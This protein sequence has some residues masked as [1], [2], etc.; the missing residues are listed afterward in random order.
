MSS[1][2]G[3]ELDRYVELR[4][5]L[6][7][8]DERHRLYALEYAEQLSMGE[9]APSAAGLDRAI[10]REVRRRIWEEWLTRIRAMPGSR[11]SS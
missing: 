7:G 6:A 11:W 4:Q 8:L 10:V 5:Y 2:F 3:N 1:S 9:P